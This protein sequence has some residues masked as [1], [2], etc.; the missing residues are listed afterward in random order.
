MTVF[1]PRRAVLAFTGADRVSFLQGLVT[2]DLQTLTQDQAVWSALLTPQGRWLSEFFLF[3]QGDHILMDCAAEHA[4]FLAKKLSRF[5]L[6]SDVQI[7]RTDLH[8]VVGS[9]TEDLPA[10]AVIAAADPRCEG[11]GWR[12]IVSALPEHSASERDY[13]ERRLALGLPDNE[14]FVSEQTLALEANMDLLNGVSWKKGCYMGQELTARTHYRG[15][16]KKRMLP[17]T[18]MGASFPESGGIV[19]MEDR[20]V[21]EIRSRSGHHA[22][23]VLRREAWSSNTLTCNGHRLSINWPLWFP[24]EMRS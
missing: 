22:I 7:N 2:N 21:G 6:R 16:L 9:G 5:R 15:L 3:A 10:D 1:L 23:A 11:A 8:V 19:M 18:L 17:V 4:D 13:L 12:A 20:E 24:V 14:D